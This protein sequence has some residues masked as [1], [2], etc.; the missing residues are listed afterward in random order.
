MS[1]TKEHFLSGWSLTKVIAALLFVNVIITFYSLD[2]NKKESVSFLIRSTAKCSF[3]LFMLA[4]VAS[5]LYHYVKNNF[6]KWLL[7]NRRYIG[8]AFAI[9]HYIHLGALLLMT[10]HISFNVFEDRGIFRTSV[11]ATAYAFMTLMTITSFD[12]TSNLFGAHN[13]KRIHTIGG[14]LLWIIFAKSYILDM[15]SPVR[16]AFAIIAIGVLVL[17]ISIL[18]RKKTSQ[19]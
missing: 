18:F 13:W 19:Y 16:I 1:N 5:S 2:M 15:T 4:F 9:S 10:L 6:T 12:K 3:I 7:K 11:G 8:V 17:R 14:Y